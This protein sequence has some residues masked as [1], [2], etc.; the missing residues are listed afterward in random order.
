[1][2]KDVLG[3][4]AE[5]EWERMMPR[6]A[7]SSNTSYV[8]TFQKKT[9][10]QLSKNE[11]DSV[12]HLDMSEAFWDQKLALFHDDLWSVPGVTLT[13]KEF[14]PILAT[15]RKMSQH[16]VLTKTDLAKFLFSLEHTLVPSQGATIAKALKASPSWES[17]LESTQSGVAQFNTKFHVHLVMAS[18]LSDPGRFVDISH[19]Q[20]NVFWNDD[21]SGCV[22]GNA[23]GKTI[24]N[25]DV[26]TSRKK[27][28]YATALTELTS[29]RLVEPLLTETLHTTSGTQRQP[30]RIPKLVATYLL[31]KMLGVPPNSIDPFQVSWLEGYDVT[32]T[33]FFA[34]VQENK[35]VCSASSS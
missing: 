9:W 5:E 6:R 12:K 2:A 30:P 10:S 13:S 23:G 14:S 25:D 28:T 18:F 4:E 33:I 32:L 3:I 31:D 24:M 34:P 17:L 35:P 20:L 29:R 19:E 1:M 7:Y 27:K 21:S 26:G 11:Q 8:L 15:I 16:S 22:W